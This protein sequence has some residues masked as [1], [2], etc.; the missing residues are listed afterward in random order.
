[1]NRLARIAVFGFLI[2]LIPF[3]I[4]IFFYSPDGELLVQKELF[5]TIMVM[6]GSVSAGILIIR[7]FKKV[8]AGYLAEGVFVGLAWLA[9]NWLLDI[10]ILI[11]MSGMTTRAYFAEIGLRYVAIPAM[12]IAAGAVAEKAAS[13]KSALKPL[14]K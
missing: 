14:K 6:S 4:S 1:M 9:I 7:Y 8:E 13:G 11:P 10:I 12:A 3:V 5:K 2:W